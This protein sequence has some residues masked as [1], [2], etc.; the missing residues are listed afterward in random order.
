LARWRRPIFLAWWFL[1]GERAS[2]GL[3]SMLGDTL[4][5]RPPRARHVWSTL[6]GKA[7]GILVAGSKA[8][9]HG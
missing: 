3:A 5:G 4:T 7:E 1:I 9:G 2:C 6:K 8:A